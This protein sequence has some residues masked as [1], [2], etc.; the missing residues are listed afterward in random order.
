MKKFFIELSKSDNRT[1]RN[2]I[3]KVIE[4]SLEGK[5]ADEIAQIMGVTR[6]AVNAYKKRAKSSLKKKLSCR[7]YSLVVLI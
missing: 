3:V 1:P 4:L 5:H 6:N 7:A 2:L